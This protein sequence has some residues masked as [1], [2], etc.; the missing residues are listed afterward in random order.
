MPNSLI[1]AALPAMAGIVI[2]A[3]LVAN[4]IHIL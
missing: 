2:T 3:V 1:G 4:N